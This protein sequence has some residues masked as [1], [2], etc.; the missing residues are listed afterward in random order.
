MKARDVRR[1]ES[2][3]AYLPAPKHPSFHLPKQETYNKTPGHIELHHNQDRSSI[4][5]IILSILIQMPD[6]AQMNRSISTI[7]TELEYL[8]DSGVLSLQQLDSITAQ[9]PVGFT[10][11]IS[12][13]TRGTI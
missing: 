6:V 10:F 7:R 13:C 4:E 1:S 2:Q 5:P 12:I 8:R 11:D 3:L 9:L